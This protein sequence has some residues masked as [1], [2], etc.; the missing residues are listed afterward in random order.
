MAVL[1]PVCVYALDPLNIH[2]TVGMGGARSLLVSCPAP[3]MHVRERIWSKG[4]HFLV[5]EVRILR[6]NQNAEPWS[7]DI[8]GICNYAWSVS[9]RVRSVYTVRYGSRKWRL[10]SILCIPE[11]PTITFQPDTLVQPFDQTLS[12]AC[13][14]GA[15]HETRSLHV[16][17]G[18]GVV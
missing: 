1:K 7:H 10:V 8:S 13:M 4:S 14:K 16:R 11:L 18:R 12:R 5:L 3:F 15:G 9:T 17:G 2:V 6:P